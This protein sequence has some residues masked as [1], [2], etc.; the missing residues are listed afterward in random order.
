MALQIHPSSRVCSVL[1]V[2]QQPTIW[3]SM[4]ALLVSPSR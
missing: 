2:F 4:V 3:L 1:S